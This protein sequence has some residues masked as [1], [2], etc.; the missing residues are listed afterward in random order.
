L[1]KFEAIDENLNNSDDTFSFAEWIE[2]IKTVI[3]KPTSKTLIM[4]KLLKSI[5]KSLGDVSQF[6]EG[7]DIS[8]DRTFAKA[9]S[10]LSFA[11]CMPQ[12]GGERRIRYYLE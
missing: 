6:K 11:A 4:K 12:V 3:R 8:Q 9:W 5:T 7:N 10:S 2:T 1:N